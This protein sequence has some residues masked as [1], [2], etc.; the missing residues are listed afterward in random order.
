MHS[1]NLAISPWHFKRKLNELN[2][3]AVGCFLHHDS[4]YSLKHRATENVRAIEL[5][6]ER[7]CSTSPRIDYVSEQ[8]CHTQIYQI[9]L[10]L[11]KQTLES[12]ARPT[13]MR[14]YVNEIIF[15][16][17]SATEATE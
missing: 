8:D 5:R 11:Y 10:R 2:F 3:Q 14:Y 16:P 12:N 1:C 4:G 7:L 6:A 17:C 13:T 15:I 9:I